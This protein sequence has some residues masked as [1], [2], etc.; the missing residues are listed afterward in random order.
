MYRN[1][2]TTIERVMHRKKKALNGIVTE[3]RDFLRH[4][5]WRTDKQI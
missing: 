2:L 3:V 5:K 4:M 1:H